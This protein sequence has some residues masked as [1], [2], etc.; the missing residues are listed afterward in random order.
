VIYQ[1]SKTSFFLDFSFFPSSPQLIE[2]YRREERKPRNK[3]FESARVG[4][5]EI[6]ENGL[7]LRAKAFDSASL[8]V[9]FA[10]N[11]LKQGG[12]GEL[13]GGGEGGEV[14]FSI[15]DSATLGQKMPGKTLFFSPPSKAY[16]F[17]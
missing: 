6:L 9:V 3:N 2:R 11:C 8:L 7:E 17:L 10:D 13:S 16:S 15:D 1:S 14:D 4:I 12:R 5:G